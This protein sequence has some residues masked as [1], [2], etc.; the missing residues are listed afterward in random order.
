MTG[1]WPIT[2]AVVLLATGACFGALVMALLVGGRRFDDLVELR[3]RERRQ[4]VLDSIASRGR[5]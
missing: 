5:K 3:D 2:W 4:R 1:I